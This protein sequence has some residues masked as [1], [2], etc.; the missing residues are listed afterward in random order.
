LKDLK[1]LSTHPN[2]LR[3][4]GGAILD[5]ASG[6]DYFTAGQKNSLSFTSKNALNP[7]PKVAIYVSYK[8]L[9][10]D[11]YENVLFEALHRSGFSII[12]V[13][14]DLEST[15]VE[16]PPDQISRKNNGRDL[17]AIRDIFFYLDTDVVEEL[18]IFNSSLAYLSNIEKFLQSIR[19]E[20]TDQVTVGVQ[21]YQKLMHFQSFFYYASGKGIKSLKDLFTV[22][23]DVR[24]K[25]SLINFG[26]ILISRRLIKSSVQLNVL[27]P[28]ENVLKRK[29]PWQH[30]LGISQ[31]PSL[32]CAEELIALGAPFVKRTHPK[33]QK[34]LLSDRGSNQY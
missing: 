21:S 27:Y 13:I 8:S 6:L 4:L 10:G 1:K 34:I 14:N 16:S 3:R 25:R 30:R 23:R 22:V 24:Y 9:Q 33:V 29:L 5:L 7:I 19:Q 26:E 15:E 12:K 11:K 2:Y 17:G 32:H 28:Y 31:N 20:K 18:F